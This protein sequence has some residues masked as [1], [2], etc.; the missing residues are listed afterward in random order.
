[1]S[2]TAVFLRKRIGVLD[3]SRRSCVWMQ[4]LSVWGWICLAGAAQARVGA[5]HP[6]VPGDVPGPRAGEG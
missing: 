5:H 1:M 3:A 6:Q 4:C 2:S